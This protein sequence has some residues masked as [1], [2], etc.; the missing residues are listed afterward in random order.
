VKIVYN[1]SQE[2]AFSFLVVCFP[3][4]SALIVVGALL[5]SNT[6][7]VGVTTHWVIQKKRIAIDKS[8]FSA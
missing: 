6:G 7:D 4:L 3:S 1:N 5:F 2:T 8:A